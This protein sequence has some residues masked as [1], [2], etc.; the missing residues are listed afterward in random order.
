MSTFFRQ[1]SR[2][3][4]V[5]VILT[6][7]IAPARAAEEPSLSEK[8]YTAAQTKLQPLFEASKWPEVIVAIDE[9]L[10]TTGPLSID[11]GFLLQMKVQALANKGDNVGAMQAL[12]DA[13][14]IADKAGFWDFPKAM[15]IPLSQTLVYLGSLYMQE[16]QSAGKSPEA[17][18]AAYKK[19]QGYIRRLVDLTPN[20][21]PEHQFLL[22][23]VL[24]YQAIADQ[25]KVDTE[26]LKQ[27]QAEMDKVMLLTLTPKEDAY[28]LQLAIYQGLGEYGKMSELLELMLKKYPSNKGNW[29]QLFATYVS[30]QGQEVRSILTIERARALGLMKSPKDN[31]TLASLYYNAQQYYRAAEILKEGLETGEIEVSERR[32]WELWADCYMRLGLEDK[33]IAVYR[34]AIPKF[35]EVGNF[36]LQIGQIYYNRDNQEEALKCMKAAVSKKLADSQ[37][38]QTYYFIAFLSLELKNLDEALPAARKAVEL[39]PRSR[40]NKV[41]LDAIES[42]IKAREDYKKNRT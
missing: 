27:A 12:E 13:L 28:M 41:L 42:S 6:V 24:F 30:Q 4:W 5:A 10:A 18:R 1:F 31:F 22:V 8:T 36:D 35:P 26:L 37:I 9:I 20:P 3:L 19:A 38:A 11:R 23:Q 14:Q 21:A 34:Q 16:A 33:A 32:N 29:Q 2:S 39:D 40:T 17:Q 15:P 7:G 25:A